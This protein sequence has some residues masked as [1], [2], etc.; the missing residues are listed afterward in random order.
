MIAPRAATIF[1][2]HCRMLDFTEYFVYICISFSKETLHF[3]MWCMCVCARVCVCVCV[4]VCACVCSSVLLKLLVSEIL[5][6]LNLDNFDNNI[7][8]E[9][10]MKG[11][12]LLVLIVLVL[13]CCLSSCYRPHII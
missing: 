8:L 1:T 12:S 2:H 10:A 5:F 9:V 7:P 3:N 11:Y 13:M 6:S 4:R